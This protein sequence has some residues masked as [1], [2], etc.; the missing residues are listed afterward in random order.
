MAIT[1]HIGGEQGGDFPYQWTIEYDDV[2][3][4]VTAQATADPVIRAITVIVTITAGGGTRKVQ[5]VQS[6]RAADAD[7]DFPVTIGAGNVVIGPTV[8]PAQVAR[9][10]GK[11]GTP[12]GGLPFEESWSRV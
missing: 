11:I 8:Q 1:A 6:G 9:I 12:V 10:V 3:R 5:F 7:T 2:T 4:R